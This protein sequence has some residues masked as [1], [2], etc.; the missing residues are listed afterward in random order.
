M[1]AARVIN[2]ISNHILSHQTSQFK[3]TM[4]QEFGEIPKFS[5]NTTLVIRKIAKR[6]VNF[7]KS[8]LIYDEMSSV[9]QHFAEAVQ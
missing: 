8:H 9:R 1:E 3:P 7:A 4:F 5:I 2:V 6:S